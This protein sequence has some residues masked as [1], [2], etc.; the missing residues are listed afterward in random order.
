MTRRDYHIMHTQHFSVMIISKV[1]GRWVDKLG[2]S[3]VLRGA[4]ENP[5]KMKSDTNPLP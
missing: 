1:L 5:P 2:V 4:N 3:L